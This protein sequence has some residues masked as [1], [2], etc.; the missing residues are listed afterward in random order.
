MRIIFGGTP[1]PARE[2]LKRLVDSHHDVVGVL[3]RRDARRGRGKSLTPSPVAAYAEEL[4]IPVLKP[5]T[6]K[7]NDEAAS[8][9]R[10]LR[11]DCIPVVAYGMLIPPEL[12]EVAPHGWVNVHYSLLPAWRGAAPVQA[13]IAHGDETVGV[14]V[15]RIDEGLDT[16]P[17]L[18]TFETPADPEETADQLLERLTHAGADLLVS[19]LDRLEAGD[20]SVSP[21]IGEPTFAPKISV[22]SA[23]IDWAQPAELIDRHIR[24]VTPNPGAWTLWN[25]TRIKLGPVKQSSS[26]LQLSPGEVAVGSKEVHVG[27]G[28]QPVLLSTLQA[29]GKKMMNAV[30]W[31][32]GIHAAA[33]IMWA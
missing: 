33:P 4:G 28:T 2:T 29:P 3:S 22:E 23:R 10:G 5:E 14:S 31:A 7:G 32:R 27:T 19:V 15:F 20:I 24:A 16:G 9:I 30:D 17:I 12:L 18:D 11:P 26:D 1:S 6:L 25:D 21:Q 13:S 8:W